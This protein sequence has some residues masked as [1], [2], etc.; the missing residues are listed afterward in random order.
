MATDPTVLTVFVLVYA[1]MLFGRLPGLTL[2][3]AGIA[4]CGAIALVALGRVPL[5]RAWTLVDVPTIALLFGLMIVSAELRSAG[6]YARLTRELGELSGGAPRLL[7]MTMA[8]TAL[9][10]ALLANDIVCLAA[11]P[12]LVAVCAAR[13][14]APAPFLIGHACAANIGSAATLIGNPQNMLIGATLDLSFR[15]YTAPAAR[16]SSRCR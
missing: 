7:W 8:G 14:L 9:L 13:R 11:T 4:L 10:A 5:E 12:I 15:G 3:R 2:D 6:A 1:G 16:C